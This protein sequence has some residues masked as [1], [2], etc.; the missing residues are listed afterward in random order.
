MGSWEQEDECGTIDIENDD[1]SA[2]HV[3]RDMYDE[4]P[5][6][7]CFVQWTEQLM[8]QF[9]NNSLYLNSTIVQYVGSRTRLLRFSP[10]T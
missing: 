9:A 2:V 4:D 5:D 6:V 1:N 7:L 10:R 3:P 8:E